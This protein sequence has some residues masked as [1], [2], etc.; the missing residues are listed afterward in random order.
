MS[1]EGLRAEA[2]V[3]CVVQGPSKWCSDKGP[4]QGSC[5]RP[6]SGPYGEPARE[7]LQVLSHCF[8]KSH[9][10]IKRF[11]CRDLQNFLAFRGHRLAG[12]FPRAAEC[13]SG[14]DLPRQAGTDL[15]FFFLETPLV[16]EAQ[17]FRAVM[18]SAGHPKSLQQFWQQCNE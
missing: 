15:D 7:R 14:D 16:N 4:V 12:G 13:I 1:R 17:G 3:A 8:R 2:V 6:P 10:S 5:K 11:P 18:P 9:Q